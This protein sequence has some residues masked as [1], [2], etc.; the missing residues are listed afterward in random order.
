MKT[1]L[2][3]V[4]GS[5]IAY[6]KGKIF[7]IQNVHS[8]EKLTAGLLNNII[9]QANGQE[10]PSNQNFVNTD[11]GT[12]FIS[13][14]DYEVRSE[15]G[16]LNKILQAYI[17]YAPMLEQRPDTYIK[18]GDSYSMK[19][20]VFIN[21][22]KDK[23]SMTESI[24]INGE[25]VKEVCLI[26]RDNSL[27]ALVTDE[28]LTKDGEVQYDIYLPEN[29]IY[30]DVYELIKKSDEKNV[31]HVGYVLAIT[32]SNE[33]ATKEAVRTIVSKD[34]QYDFDIISLV[35]RKPFLSQTTIKVNRKEEKGFVQYM[36]GS[37]DIFAGRVMTDTK[38]SES[39]VGQPDPQLNQKSID[40]ETLIIP[41]E[42]GNDTEVKN[43]YQ[44]FGFDTA[45]TED[46]PDKDELKKYGLI[47]RYIDGEDEN[48]TDA[49]RY[50]K[51]LRCPIYQTDMIMTDGEQ[52]SIELLIS[53][54]I[55]YFQLYNFDEKDENITADLSTIYDYD[56]LVRDGT[57]LKYLNLS[58]N[59][60]SLS[61]EI[62]TIISSELCILISSDISNIISAIVEDTEIQ[63]LIPDGDADVIE[64]KSIQRKQENNE[65]YYQLYNF[66]L[67]TTFDTD[68]STINN[69]DILVRDGNELKYTK[70]SID[71]NDISV[72]VDNKSI[73]RNSNDELQLFN[74]SNGNTTATD[75]AN[76]LISDSSDKAEIVVRQSGE[77]NYMPIGQLNIN[78]GTELSVQEN[79]ILGYEL[80]YDTSDYAITLKRGRLV[81]ENNVLKLVPDS[82]LT[83]KIGTTPISEIIR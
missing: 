60:S 35:A 75:L 8:G 24:L 15:S 46:I 55:P 21:L 79:T 6:N 45:K 17:D 10:I 41:T 48:D 71:T 67:A 36:I 58:A 7:M 5:R 20:Y 59:L 50:V 69:Y 26:C 4:D 70:L 34:G 11:K 77:V 72:K 1:E 2:K 22:G 23:L 28:F 18:N 63:A 66:D 32:G 78:S 40:E 25:A 56:I 54:D 9:A 43:Y 61:S 51:Y 3:L 62:S 16:E 12:L 38:L 80:E 57:T 74:F 30:A 42:D 52:N 33:D 83:Q 76:T 39:L 73:N 14:A 13:N 44:I 47:A 64:Q 53:D 19:P 81:I 82:T 68:V 31:T 27:D 65:D 49:P 37:Q 29:P